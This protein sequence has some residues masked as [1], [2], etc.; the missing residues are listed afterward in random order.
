ML[1]EIEGEINSNTKVMREFTP[2]F[3][4]ADIKLVREQRL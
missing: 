1:I 3:H 4:Q 2:H